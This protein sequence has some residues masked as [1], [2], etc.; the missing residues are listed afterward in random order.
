MGVGD[1]ASP[2]WLLHRRDSWKRSH[3]EGNATSRER[4]W[5]IKVHIFIYFIFL[6]CYLS[7]SHTSRVY[8][9][10]IQWICNQFSCTLAMSP[11]FMICET[12]V[13][14][15]GRKQ[16]FTFCISF[17]PLVSLMPISLGCKVWI[18][19]ILKLLMK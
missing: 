11:L 1:G 16:Q 17:L 3:R 5:R 2:R 7:N 18:K 10:E 4:S 19:N 12:F 14:F 13:R 6:N 9:R 15:S 8:V